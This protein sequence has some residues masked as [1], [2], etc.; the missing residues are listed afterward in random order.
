MVVEQVIPGDVQLGGGV[1]VPP[2]GVVLGVVVIVVDAVVVDGG[3]GE[4]QYSGPHFEYLMLVTGH[5][6]V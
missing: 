5:E 1:V 6:D 2:V 3:V 4:T